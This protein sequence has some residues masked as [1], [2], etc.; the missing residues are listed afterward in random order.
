MSLHDGD[1]GNA[2]GRREAFENRDA[3]ERRAR[4]E[5]MDASATRRRLEA[6]R[7]NGER[8]DLAKVV[9]MATVDAIAGR[10][11]EGTLGALRAMA[12]GSMRKARAAAE[13]PNIL[14]EDDARDERVRPMRADKFRDAGGSMDAD[15]RTR[16]ELFGGQGVSDALNSLSVEDY[17]H[18]M[19]MRLRKHR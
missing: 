14:D 2:R 4:Q 17:R 6:G 9:A 8:A 18:I 19:S 1:F 13:R 11:L 3:I 5:A 7:P 12:Q 16:S 10:T 15:A